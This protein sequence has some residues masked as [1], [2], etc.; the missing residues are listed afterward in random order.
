[1]ISLMVGRFLSL[2]KNNQADIHI[3][4]IDT[5]RLFYQKKGIKRFENLKAL[6]EMFLSSNTIYSRSRCVLIEFSRLSDI[7]NATVLY[8][9]N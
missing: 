3:V 2:A 5:D 9:Q 4:T 7:L 8:N 6:R 1:M